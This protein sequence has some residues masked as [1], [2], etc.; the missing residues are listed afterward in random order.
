[1]LQVHFRYKYVTGLG[2]ILKVLVCACHRLK[3]PLYGFSLY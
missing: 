2:K 3:D 1:V